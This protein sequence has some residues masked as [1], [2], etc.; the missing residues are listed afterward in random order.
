MPL[1]QSLA[2]EAGHQGRIDDFRMPVTVPTIFPGQDT[3]ELLIGAT[4]YSV[5]IPRGQYET[6]LALAQAIK[7]LLQANTVGSW[8][9]TY[10]ARNVTMEFRNDNYDYVFTGGTWMSKLLNRPYTSTSRVYL[11]SYVP[12]QGLDVCYLCCQQFQHMDSVGPKGAND[13]ICSIPITA[14][15]GG[16][17]VYSMSNEVWFDIPALLTQNSSFQ[18][19][20]RDYNI[21]NIVPNISFTLTID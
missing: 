20:D 10:D 3:I 19:R 11:F 13:I 1:P 14:P 9:V 8:L 17:Q 21:L 4:T 15:F 7:V 2:L 6:G 12:A 18:L 16:V 5:T